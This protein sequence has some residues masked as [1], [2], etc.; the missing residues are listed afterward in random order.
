MGPEETFQGHEGPVRVIVLDRVD[1]F[2]ASGGQDMTVNIWEI[3]SG[4]LLKVL[5]G[6]NAPVN[7]V[8]FLTSGTFLVTGSGSTK[9]GVQLTDEDWD[10]ETVVGPYNIGNGNTVK[11]WNIESGQEM[12]SLGSSERAVR[13]VCSHPRNANC[14]MVVD[15]QY[16]LFLYEFDPDWQP[17]PTR[18][19][20]GVRAA[21]FSMDVNKMVIEGQ[22]GISRFGPRKLSHYREISTITDSR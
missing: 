21:R 14:L 5:G 22:D 18:V 9:S 20:R 19:M 11:I 17:L 3:A 15:E 1:R 6:Y 7:S 4:R 12:A 13:Q 8:S 10:M 2:M 16:T